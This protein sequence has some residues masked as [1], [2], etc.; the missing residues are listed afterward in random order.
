MA[1]RGASVSI[2]RNNGGI[3]VEVLS[4]I[5]KRNKIQAFLHVYLTHR[6]DHIFRR[7]DARR[8]DYVV[9]FFAPEKVE[10]VLGCSGTGEIP[11][12]DVVFFEDKELAGGVLGTN[13]N[14]AMAWRH[15]PKL[16]LMY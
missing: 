4:E 7:R 15:S 11:E 2:I 14:S 9:A 5:A 1:E 10:V 12:P 16:E 3:P 6:H 13:P 8:K